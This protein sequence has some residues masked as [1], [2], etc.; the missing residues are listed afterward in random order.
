MTYPERAPLRLMAG[1][2]LQET[3]SEVED[4]PETS[5]DSGGEEGAASAVVTVTSGEMDVSPA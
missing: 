1:G 5:T 4:S 2:G 3:R